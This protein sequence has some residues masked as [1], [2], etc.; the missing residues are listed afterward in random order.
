M[1]SQ[2]EQIAHAIETAYKEAYIDGYKQALKDFSYKR[3]DIVYVGSGE[4]TLE[5]ALTRLK[6]MSLS[7][8]Q[9]KG[10]GEAA[11]HDPF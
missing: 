3:G 11:P 8:S 2:E 1:P 4:M 6:D 5:E 9:P 7:P 10:H